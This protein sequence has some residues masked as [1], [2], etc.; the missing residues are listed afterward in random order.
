MRVFNKYLFVIVLITSSCSVFEED[1]KP[2]N[3]QTDIYDL[4]LEELVQIDIYEYDERGN[5]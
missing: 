4:S 5:N 1:V 3:E 2:E